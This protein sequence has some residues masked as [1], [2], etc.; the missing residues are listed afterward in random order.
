MLGGLMDAAAAANAEA[1]ARRE[2]KELVGKTRGLKT[3][4]AVPQ[5]LLERKP[6]ACASVLSGQG[7]L[8]VTEA[9]TESTAAALLSYVEAENAR[10]QSAVLDGLVAFDA[11]FGGVNCRGLSGG[12]FGQRQDL[13]L[14]LSAPAVRLAARELARNL[15]S[16][17]RAVAGDQV[18]LHEISSIVAEP[19]APRQCVHADTIVLPC[20]QYPNVS[21]A[22]LWTFFVALQN[23]EDGM[24][25]TQFLPY[26]HTPDAHV[27]WNAAARNE[28]LKDR[29]IAAQPAMQS[30]LRVG[31]AAAFDSRLLHCGCANE[32]QKRRVLFYLTFSRDAD[33]PLPDGLHGSNSIRAEDKGRWTL[34]QLCDLEV[35]V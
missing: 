1:L 19:G 3:L 30:A 20:P 14:P 11:R 31:D 12:P 35:E 8:G 29:F 22:P 15:K 9:L 4:T 26:T 2:G 33:W 13:W 10:C 28:R 16:L 25:H 34:Q 6:E 5:T 17:L 23:V 27:L 18:T 7:C 32:S 24:G 21:M